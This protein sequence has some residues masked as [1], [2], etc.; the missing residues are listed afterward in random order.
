MASIIVT[1]GNEVAGY[2]IA[3]YLGIVRGIVVRSPTI[4]QGF[5]GGLKQIVGGNIESYTEA[6][7]QARKESYLRMLE[8]ADERAPMPLSPWAMMS[9]SSARVRLK[10]WRMARRFAWSGFERCRIGRCVSAKL[11]WTQEDSRDTPPLGN[12]G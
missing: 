3:E 7:E 2:R 1:T 5:L 6:C 10:S 11:A 9:P 4:A 12:G 8:Y